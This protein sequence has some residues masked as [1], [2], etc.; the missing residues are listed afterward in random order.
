MANLEGKCN[1][2]QYKEE[3]ILANIA[4]LWRGLCYSTYGVCCSK[5][6]EKQDCEAG[7]MAAINS[8]SCEEKSSTIL[9]AAG[10]SYTDCCRSCQV[11][12][13]VKASGNDCNDTTLFNDF[14]NNI[15]YQLCC[16]NN[17][18]NDDGETNVDH[19]ENKTSTVHNSAI[20]L[21][22]KDH[23]PSMSFVRKND[24]FKDLNS[25]VDNIALQNVSISDDGAIVLQANDGE[26]IILLIAKSLIN[27]IFD[28]HQ[29]I[30]CHLHF[31]FHS[32]LPHSTQLMQII[33]STLN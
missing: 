26:L 15:S 20:Y 10:T 11:G 8:R 4:P 24:A 29:S 2:G 32:S 12:L 17:D 3:N 21:I 16:L 33:Q 14:I 13:A 18:D 28:Y 7:R 9:H 6:L 27:C 31:H 1:G 19:N 30:T 25:I 5:E 22:D 23:Q